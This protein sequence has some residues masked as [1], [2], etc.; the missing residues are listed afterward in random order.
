MTKFVG[1]SRVREGGRPVTHY[2]DFISHTGGT[3]WRHQAK[4]LDMNPAILGSTNAQSAIENVYNLILDSGTGFISIGSITGNPGFYATGKYNVNSVETPTLKDAIDAAVLD[5]RLTNGGVILLLPGYYR[6]SSTITIPSGI[7]LIGEGPGVYIIGET[8]GSNP[9]FNVNAVTTDFSINGDSGLGDQNLILGTGVKKNLFKNL[10]ITDNS[11]GYVNS[12]NATLSGAAMIL[13]SRGSNIECEKVT[14]IGRL[15]DGPTLNRIKTTSGVAVFPLGLSKGTSIVINNCYFDGMRTPIFFRSQLGDSDYLSVKNNK[16]KFY[17]EES[18]SYSTNDCAIVSS[19]ANIEIEN[20][21]FV[22]AGS[23]SETILGVLNDVVPNPTNC[24]VKVVGN[25]GYTVGN[26]SRP[27]DF[28]YT[29]TVKAAIYGNAFSVGKDGNK[30]WVIVLGMDEGDLLGEG[31]LDLLLSTYDAASEVST[32]VI[33]NPGNYDLTVASG[34]FTSLKLEG[35]IIGKRYPQIKLNLSGVSVDALSNKYILFGNRIENIY[36]SS[37]G[38]FQSVHAGSSFP[39]LAGDKAEGIV[40]NNCIFK[41][42]NL[43]LDTD[44]FD[45][46]VAPTA[47][48]DGSATKLHSH[49]SKCRFYQSSAFSE[50]WSL[51]LSAIDTVKLTDSYFHGPGYALIFGDP[52]PSGTNISNFIID[53]CVFDLSGSIINAL[54]AIGNPYYIN[55]SYLTSKVKIKNSAFLCSSDG[56]SVASVFSGINTNKDFISILSS[57]VS[58]DSC[59]FNTPSNTYSVSGNL[60]PINGLSLYWTN[61]INIS[62]NIFNSSGLPI[63]V[64]INDTEDPLTANQNYCNISNNKISLIDDNYITILDF[65]V[66]MDSNDS[67]YRTVNIESNQFLSTADSTSVGRNVNHLFVT[68]ATYNAVGPVQIY[69]QGADVIF[70][71]NSLVLGSKPP[72][73]SFSHHAGVIINTYDTDG[74]TS[75]INFA[76]NLV[77]V[78]VKNKAPGTGNYYASVALTSNYINVSGNRI[79]AN[80]SGGLAATGTGFKGCLVLNC[81]S[82]SNSGDGIVTNNIF[83]RTNSSGTLTDLYRGYIWIPSVTNVRGQIVDNSFISPYYSGINKSLLLDDTSSAKNWTFAR[84]KNQTVTFN[85]VGSTGQLGMRRGSPGTGTFLYTVSG[86]ILGST[87]NTSELAFRNRDGSDYQVSFFYRDVTLA[88][89][90]IWS[91]SMTEVLPPGASLLEVSANI[92]IS[93]TLSNS[94]INGRLQ[95]ANGSTSYAD[96]V[97][98]SASGVSYALDVTTIPE[99]RIRSDET[100]DAG[101]WYIELFLDVDNDNSLTCNIE[102]LEIIYRY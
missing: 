58:I 68:G 79:N 66:D 62:N 48:F 71:N 81:I 26:I 75:S 87:S 80:N 12:G 19:L 37:V 55:I 30:P 42:T 17:G 38:A 33:L 9:I 7:S 98:I 21:L 61:T 41:D 54:P 39:S 59:Y 70:S 72:F 40:I 24:S 5:S 96:T 89:S 49:V 76:N 36:F 1:S 43:Y 16:I 101:P 100:G 95:V 20:N 47:A 45:S 77:D 84:N 2:Q 31:A 51:A 4:D 10:I 14:F 73:S 29:N 92:N 82:R 23:Y 35:N 94:T 44:G 83:D 93:G 53:G 11:D 90:M 25:S 86:L 69:A 74:K 78:N 97:S 6:V 18:V 52:F 28:V 50:N 85:C 67:I 102:F 34:T 99:G 64:Q 15:N 3:D 91:M 57:D 27:V 63:K 60:F 46:S 65:D 32:K 22:G 88:M 56:N 8:S 13:G